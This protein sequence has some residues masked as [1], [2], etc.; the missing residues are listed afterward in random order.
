MEEAII[1]SR[2]PLQALERKEEHCRQSKVNQQQRIFLIRSCLLVSGSKT[3]SGISNLSRTSRLHVLML[4][5][6]VKCLIKS[7]WSVRQG[8]LESAQSGRNFSPSAS[9]RSFVR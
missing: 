8:R 5:V 3:V 2:M 6:C 1:Q 4:H 9:M 7:L